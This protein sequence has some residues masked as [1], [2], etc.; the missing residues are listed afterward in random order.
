MRISQGTT[1]MLMATFFFA[2]MQ[3]FVKML[4]RIPA[5]EVVLFRSIVSL[6]I[7]LWFLRKAKI[8]ILGK[9]RKLLI[10]RGLFG[11]AALILYFQTIQK[12]PLASAVTF[13]YLAPIFTSVLGIFIVK[14]KVA[15][16]QFGFFALA[17][18]GVLVI[19]G[20]DQRIPFVYMAFGVGGAFFA[21]LAYNMVRKLGAAEHPL[22]IILYFPLITIPIS[23]V[24]CWF[25]WVNPVG[26]EWLLL[27]LVGIFTQTAQYFMTLSYQH[28]ELS[29]VSSLNFT[30]IIY[31]LIFGY[32][33]FGEVFG[34]GAYMGIALVMLGVTLNIMYKEGLLEGTF[35]F[36]GKGFIL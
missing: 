28:E 23:L 7:S 10:F 12:I 32:A 35:K 5:V 3:V 18:A 25:D 29:K 34:W 36:F 1:Y 31:A 26:W 11:A 6:V 20:F 16:F 14:E 27:L 4:P 19:Q 21:G 30:G 22:V 9:N 17:L 13:Q 15:S 24:Y 2:L 33:F 8:S